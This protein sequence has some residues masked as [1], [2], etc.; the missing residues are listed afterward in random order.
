[1]RRRINRA[2]AIA[3]SKQKALQDRILMGSALLVSL[4]L[5]LL[6]ISP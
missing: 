6:L 1:M 4:A 2:I 3:A 5:L